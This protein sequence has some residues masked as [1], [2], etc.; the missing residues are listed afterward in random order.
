ML[1]TSNVSSRCFG[2]V[3]QRS[4]YSGKINIKVIQNYF[5]NNIVVLAFLLRFF[6]PNSQ[7]IGVYLIVPTVRL[8]LALEMWLVFWVLRTQL[9]IWAGD[10]YMFK[11]WES[12]IFLLFAALISFSWTIVTHLS[13]AIKLFHLNCTCPFPPYFLFFILSPF[14]PSCYCSFSPSFSPCTY[15]KIKYWGFGASH[16]TLCCLSC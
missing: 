15:N 9:F 16:M 12:K 3:I 4:L 2:R 6:L 8:S 5:L 1:E 11:F 7:I 13:I 10:N 14:P